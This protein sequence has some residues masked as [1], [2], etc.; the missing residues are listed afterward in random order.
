MKRAV[1]RIYLADIRPLYNEELQKKVYDRLPPARREK[2]DACGQPKARAASLAAG[3]LMEYALKDQGLTDCRIGYASGGAPVVESVD[4]LGGAAADMAVAP[5]CIAAEPSAAHISLSHSGD[6]AV[7][8]IAPCPIGVD[9][10]RI[11][12]VKAGVLRHFFPEP[13]RQ[14]FLEK[15]GL[16]PADKELPP[17]A[18][19]AFLWQW[20]A[21]ESYMKLTGLGMSMGFDQLVLERAA[22]GACAAKPGKTAPTLQ[23][24]DRQDR[25]APA[26]IRE[27]RLLEGY[28]LTVCTEKENPLK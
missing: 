28:C 3:F 10:Q 18:A 11:G 26:K 22:S 12:P 15:Y 8:A 14:D 7:C 4:G 6:Y 17:A 23:I 2:A 19:E 25:H 21:K 5:D 24:R 9:I 1:Y 20:A 16:N 27:Y 13:D